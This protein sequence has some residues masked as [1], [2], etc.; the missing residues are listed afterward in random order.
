M[1]KGASLLQCPMHKRRLPC[2]ITPNFH[3]HTIK[4]LHADFHGHL[5]VMLAKIVGKKRHDLP[6]FARSCFIRSETPLTDYPDCKK[7]KRAEDRPRSVLYN[8]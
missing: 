6:S 4:S 3:C 8:V 1:S 2:R 5:F 7:M